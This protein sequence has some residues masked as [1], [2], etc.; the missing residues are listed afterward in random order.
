MIISFRNPNSYVLSCLLNGKKKREYGLP[1]TSKEKLLKS[2][3]GFMNSFNLFRKVIYI[4]IYICVCVCVDNVRGE[5]G[6]EN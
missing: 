6:F 4:Y 5:F 1:S 3:Y 2:L